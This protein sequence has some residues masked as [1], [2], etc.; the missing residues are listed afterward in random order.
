MFLNVLTHLT[1]YPCI[2]SAHK[3]TLVILIKC[4]IH[5]WVVRLHFIVSFDVPIGIPW[6][7]IFS[8]FS[9]QNSYM[10]CSLKIQ[11]Y[12]STENRILTSRRPFTWTESSYG[13]FS[14]GVVVPLHDQELPIFQCGT[15]SPEENVFC[16]F[17]L[18]ILILRAFWLSFVVLA[19]SNE[20]QYLIWLGTCQFGVCPLE[21]SHSLANWSN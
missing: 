18:F 6:F 4:R 21:F 11:M 12:I 13:M 20:I 8:G 10:G 16:L 1:L 3:K 17:I 9:R 19:V 7:L 5:G 14:R 15:Q 2:K